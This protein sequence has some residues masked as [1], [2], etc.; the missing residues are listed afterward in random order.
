MI[1]WRY[2]TSGQV[3]G[4]F[5]LQGWG[6]E[7]IPDIRGKE[8]EEPPWFRKVLDVARLGN[9]VQ[10]VPSPPPNTILWVDTDEQR[11]LL[12]FPD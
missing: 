2:S 11:N 5:L 1:R 10:H 6:D 4:S 12:Q 3:Q 9:H 8:G 7:R